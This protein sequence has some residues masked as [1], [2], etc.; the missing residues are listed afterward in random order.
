MLTRSILQ[1]LIEFSLEVP[2]RYDS[3]NSAWENRIIIQALPLSTAVLTTKYISLIILQQS[4]DLFFWAFTLS[5]VIRVTVK[6]WMLFV[7]RLHE[8]VAIGL[9]PES[10]SLC[11]SDFCLAGLMA[12]EGFKNNGWDWDRRLRFFC[13]WID[14][15]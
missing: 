8:P 5:R 10:L 13:F 2:W 11:Q 15:I 4:C 7:Y 9:D 12:L 1:E 6:S 3:A 14:D